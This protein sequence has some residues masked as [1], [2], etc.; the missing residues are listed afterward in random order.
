MLKAFPMTKHS[1]VKSNYLR[2]VARCLST[3]VNHFS[4]IFL[5]DRGVLKF[6]YICHS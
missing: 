5:I 6:T 1:S 3:I 2:Y 4:D